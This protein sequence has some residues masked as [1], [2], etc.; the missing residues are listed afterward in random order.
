M[1]QFPIIEVEAEIVAAGIAYTR[2]WE[3]D[4]DAHWSVNNYTNIAR[5]NGVIIARGCMRDLQDGVISWWNAN[6]DL[7]R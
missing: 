2:G 5:V 3:R 1:S 7:V 4:P 6:K